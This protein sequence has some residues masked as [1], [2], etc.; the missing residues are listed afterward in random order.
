M[1]RLGFD[2]FTVISGL[3]II[4]MLFALLNVIEY[5]KFIPGGMVSKVWNNIVAL[6]SFFFLLY[7]T[8]PFFILLSHQTKDIIVAFVFL[9]GAMYVLINIRLVYRI[10]MVMK[11]E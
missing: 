5:K 8:F 7:L 2:L 6:V 11:G 10:I 1:A 9:F 4:T 3:G